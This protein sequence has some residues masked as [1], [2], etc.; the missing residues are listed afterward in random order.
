MWRGFSV[1]F[2]F[3]AFFFIYILG[4]NGVFGWY[5]IVGRFWGIHWHKTHDFEPISAKNWHFGVIFGHFW[6]FL[7]IFCPFFDNF[8]TKFWWKWKSE[9]SKIDFSNIVLGWFGNLSE[10]IFWCFRVFWG[11]LR[12]WTVSKIP[13]LVV[14]WR[15]KVVQNGPKSIFPIL[16]YG[17]L[18][19]YLRSSS[20]V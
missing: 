3:L 19:T 11:I 18:V 16:F 2:Y 10:V 6:P 5:T 13:I 15:L 20:G 7:A 9:I 12:L 4:E 14:K 17:G 1:F 8:L